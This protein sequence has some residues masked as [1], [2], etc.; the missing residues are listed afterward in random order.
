MRAA[1]LLRAEY[2]VP[3]QAIRVRSPSLPKAA[4]SRGAASIC[5]MRS[6]QGCNSAGSAASSMSRM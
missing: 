4:R 6:K 5:S 3:S 2:S 1:E